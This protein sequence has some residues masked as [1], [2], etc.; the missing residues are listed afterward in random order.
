M[1]RQCLVRQSYGG[2]VRF[3][4]SFEK[5]H[6]RC[7]TNQGYR[8]FTSDLFAYYKKPSKKLWQ[9]LHD[10][11]ERTLRCIDSNIRL[12]LEKEI[13]DTSLVVTD[14]VP[15]FG[16][17][18]I[19]LYFTRDEQEGS[20]IFRRRHIES[21]EE[22]TILEIS[23]QQYELH[24]MSLSVDESL[25]AYVVSSVFDPKSTTIKIRHLNSHLEVEVPSTT[26]KYVATVEWGPIQGNG[27]YSLFF[28]TQNKFYRSDTVR[29][30]TVSRD[31]VLTSSVIVYSNDDEAVIVDVQRTK[32]CQY[33]AISAR[34]KTSN[35]IYLVGNL[36]D[37]PI[38]VRPRQRGVQY[39][40]DVGA[41][42]DVWI[43]AN[44]SEPNHDS[45]LGEEI[46][47][48]ETTIDL[49]PLRDGFGSLRA[50]SDE[51]IIHNIDLFRQHV[52]YY[53]RSL[54]DG[55]QRMRVDNRVTG[56]SRIVDIPRDDCSILSP[57]GNIFFHA[58]KLR[59][60]VESPFSPCSTYEFD[61]ETGATNE[62]SAQLSNPNQQY[63]QQ[64]L[65]VPSLDGARI[66]MTLVHS[67]SIDPLG[68]EHCPVVL[69]GYGAYG[70]PVM[71][72]FDAT[73][74]SLLDR[75]YVV[76][77]AHT[78][79]GGELGRAWYRAGRLYEKRNSIDDFLACTELLIADVTAPSLLTAKAFSAGGVVVGAALNE[80]PE[81]FGSAVFTNAFL[82][83]SSSVDPLQPFTEHEYEEWG[84]PRVDAAAAL[85]IASYCPYSNLK[86][87][88]ACPRVLVI[89]TLDD[90]HVPFWHAVAYAKK[91]QQLRRGDDALLFTVPSGG[92]HL[93]GSRLEVASLET[94]FIV[95]NSVKARK[96]R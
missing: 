19:Y 81:L 85:L 86:P 13:K 70:E 75:G 78:R 54:I 72:G 23:F 21:G 65:L 40:I 2:F 26:Y 1:S 5:S 51:N 42:N 37:K 63:F 88:S 45:G 33:V 4:S 57:G 77:F 76:A 43:V 34:T 15:E 73:T 56:T 38:V 62:L 80:R 71:R 89:G 61:F 47:V 6:R 29:V 14:P 93:H 11:N 95:G 8:P 53:Q 69:H 31:L 17:S 46:A 35:E 18:G 36:N 59:F 50:E 68:L 94:A 60:D 28:T 52:V 39:H 10:E 30:C 16:P 87:S 92:H 84:N 91:Y 64:R 7:W 55:K 83:V 49:L 82:D 20:R 44:A 32:G 74:I 12:L 27:E 58:T 96:K 24:A 67:R 79:G 48:F 41:N 66:P 22:Q 3:S 25:M 90:S 9:E